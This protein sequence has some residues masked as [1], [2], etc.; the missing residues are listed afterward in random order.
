[1]KF[2]TFIA[3]NYIGSC[4]DVG[5]GRGIISDIYSDATEMSQDVYVPDSDEENENSTEITKE[6]FYKIFS[7]NDVPKKALKGKSKYF[8]INGGKEN[9]NIDNAKLFYIYNETQD[10]HYFFK[11]GA[12]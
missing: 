10:I 6:Q 4:V 5:Y 2:T 9:V 3:E 8:Y 12:K 7:E 1:M 11:G